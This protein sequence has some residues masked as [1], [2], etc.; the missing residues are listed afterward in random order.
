VAALA[1]G[2]SR[3]DSP[4]FGFGLVLLGAMLLWRGGGFDEA[5]LRS[6]LR[7][8]GTMPSLTG[9]WCWRCA[10]RGAEGR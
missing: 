8:A 5:G 10:R 7:I 1:T 3:G 2:D 9:R 6:L 4:G